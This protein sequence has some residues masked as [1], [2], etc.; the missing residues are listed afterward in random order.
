[1]HRER[2]SVRGQVV[3]LRDARQPVQQND[4]HILR[5]L[6]LDLARD[7]ELGKHCH[8]LHFQF[9]LPLINRLSIRG[10]IR[11]ALVLFAVYSRGGHEVL[12]LLRGRDF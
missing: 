8:V 10:I 7:A 9:A 6:G 12:D 11:R 5:N 2:I 3:L 4:A 1:M